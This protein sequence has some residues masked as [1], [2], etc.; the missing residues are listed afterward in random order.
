MAYAL[1]CTA[2]AGIFAWQVTRRA[3]ERKRQH[4]AV[5]AA[6]LWMGALGSLCYAM[7]L[8]APAGGWWFRLYYLLGAVLTA[9]YLGVGSTYLRFGT[10]AGGAALLLVTLLAVAAA[11]GLLGAPLDVQALSRL[12]GGAG[13]GVLELPGWARALMIVLNAFGT[14]AVAG[15]AVISAVD[16]ARRRAPA[17]LLGG[18]LLIAAGVLVLG[19][20]GSAAGAGRDALFWP[21]MTVGWIVIYAGFAVV[22]RTRSAGG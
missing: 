16:F 12:E 15:V 1:L 13:R 10:R 7:T 17:G 3:L 19:A 5:W 2:V 14:L 6:S 9:A 18:N 11:I 8:I 20:A 22:T 4:L 21:M